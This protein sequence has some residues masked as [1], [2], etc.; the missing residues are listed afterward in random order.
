[1]SKTFNRTNSLGARLWHQLAADEADMSFVDV[2]SLDHFVRRHRRL[3]VDRLAALAKL[4][5]DK[6][7]Y[8]FPEQ[9]AAWRKELLSGFGWDHADAI[10]AAIRREV[11]ESP[12]LSDSACKRAFRRAVAQTRGAREQ[13]GGPGAVAVELLKQA[14][15]RRAS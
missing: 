7:R 2:S 5:L 12:A 3:P 15:S 8:A 6:V 14:R 9:T 11:G 1:M 13:C 4:E 10:V